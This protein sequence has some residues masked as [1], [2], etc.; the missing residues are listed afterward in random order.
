[1]TFD[2]SKGEEETIVHNHAAEPWKVTLVDT[3]TETL[4]GGRIKRIQRYIGNAT[5][6]LTYGDGVSDVNIKELVNFHKSHRKVATVTAVRPLGRFGALSISAN[7][8]VEKFQEKTEGDNAWINAGFFVLEPKVLDY[9][10]GD[11]I[12]FEKEPVQ[13]L[14]RDGQLMAYRHTGFWQP[15]DALREKNILE[16][17]WK[18]GKAPWKVWK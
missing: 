7:N 8:R 9:I 18:S 5:F 13:N 1:M 3:G 10:E 16:N 14:A 2:F 15:M 12:L 17:L 11:Q 6:M 4:T